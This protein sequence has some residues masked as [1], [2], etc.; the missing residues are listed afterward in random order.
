MPAEHM[1]LFLANPPGA[2]FI[3][4]GD[5]RVEWDRRARRSIR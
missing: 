4:S 1:A 3:M 2:G 5:R